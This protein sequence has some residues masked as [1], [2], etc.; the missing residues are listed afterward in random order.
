MR[1]VYKPCFAEVEGVKGAGKSS[2]VYSFLGQ[3]EGEDAG[4]ICHTG[5]I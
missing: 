3:I 2:A 5:Y 4:R 1:Y